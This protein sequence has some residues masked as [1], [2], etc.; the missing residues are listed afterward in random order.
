VITARG[1]PSRSA[2]LAVIMVPERGAASTIATAS[3]SATITA[4]RLANI[5]LVGTVPGGCA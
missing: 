5:P 1:R 3:Q 4:L 2:R